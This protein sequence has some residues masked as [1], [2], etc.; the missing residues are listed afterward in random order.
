MIG[1]GIITR[2]G[3]RRATEFTRQTE[4][5][6]KDVARHLANWKDRPWASITAYDSA[7]RAYTWSEQTFGTDGKRIAK[8]GGR[9][10]NKDWMPAYG[11]GDGS[12]LLSFPAEV[13]LRRTVETG[14]KGPAYEFP[15]YCACAGATSGAGIVSGPNILTPCCA[16]VAIPSTL[17][18]HI[19]FWNRDHTIILQTFNF[20]ITF[21]SICPPGAAWYGTSTSDVVCVFGGGW[22]VQ[23]SMYC[24]GVGS[25]SDPFRITAAVG[26]Y[27]P[28]RPQ[29]FSLNHVGFENPAC[30]TPFRFQI[31]YSTPSYEYCFGNI[32]QPQVCWW[33]DLLIDTNP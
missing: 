27:G 12:V 20:P 3:A 24:I 7:S 19:S 17:Y 2:A 26:C 29:C 28:G 6:R 32:V 22:R 8:S 21:P 10:G 16:G 31:P 9:T 15:V 33:F 11:F 4:T 18:A 5:N 1:P 30:G 13:R 23:V 14:T 25:V